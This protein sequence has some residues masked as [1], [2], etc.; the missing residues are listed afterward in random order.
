MKV[1]S[2]K[3][4]EFLHTFTSLMGS[5]KEGEGMPTPLLLPEYGGWK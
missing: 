5:I 3:I 2:E 1:P 4:K